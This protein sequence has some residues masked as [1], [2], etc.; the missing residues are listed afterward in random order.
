MWGAIIGDLAGSIYEFEQTKEIKSI[1]VNKII[2]PSAF[3]SD[4]TILTIA[5]LDAFLN[6]K[7]YEKYLKQYALE[8]INYRPNYEPYFKR[9]FSPGFIRWARGEGYGTSCGNGAMMRISPIAYLSSTEEELIK[10][11]IKATSCSHNSEEALTNTKTIARII[12][13][14]KKGI[15][16]EQIFQMLNL[17]P[18][19]IP[20]ETFNMTCA[21]TIN[22]CLYAIK[23][24]DSFEDAIRLIISFGGDTDTNAC[25]V[26]SIAEALYGVNK[27]LIE[28][29]KEKIPT[30]FVDK[31][32]QGYSLI[33]KDYH[34]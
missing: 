30:K 28:Q 4:D 19:Y 18:K 7:D 2:E 20:F 10:N 31:V 9:P 5:V 17:Y 21:T 8:H 33:K 16:K 32:E 3:Y 1:S 26:G 34:L 25:I 12:Y 14:A 6:D 23:V 24:T 13:L 22:N 11:T 27:D 15:P 29:A